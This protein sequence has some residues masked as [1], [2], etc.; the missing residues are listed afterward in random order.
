LS[1]SQRTEELEQTELNIHHDL[2]EECKAG[3]RSAQKKLYE[4]YCKAMYNTALRIVNDPDEAEDVLQESFISAFRNLGQ[5]RGDSTFGSWMKRIVINN[6]LNKIKKRRIEMTP[7]D[8]EHMEIEA[9]SIEPEMILS[10]ERIKQA[11]DL[12]PRGF[13]QVFTLYQFEGYDHKEIGEILGITESTSKSQYNRAKKKIKT[14][15]S[16]EVIYG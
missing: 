2:I 8:E 5:Y 16:Q 6:G 11:V 4:L 3:R 7:L 12:L 15:L 14:I 10:V 1:L 9:G 13:K